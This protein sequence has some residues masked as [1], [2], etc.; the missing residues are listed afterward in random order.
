M[1]RGEVAAVCALFASS[2]R[3]EYADDVKNGHLRFILQFGRQRDPYFGDTTSIYEVLK[4]DD[5]K[6]LADLIF[7]P[8]ALTR[9]IVAPPGL[10]EK[11]ATALRTAFSDTMAD[12]EFL[13][14][15]HHSNIEITP[16]TGEEVAAEFKGFEHVSKQLIERAK[17]LMGRN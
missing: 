7:R 16:S 14:F 17:T 6:A 4:T 1:R 2:V 9:T 8:A 3:A 12:P 11:I 5:D 13:A 10:P 15:A